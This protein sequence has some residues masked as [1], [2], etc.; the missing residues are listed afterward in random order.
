MP[1]SWLMAERRPHKSAAQFYL[2]HRGGRNEKVD[3]RGMAEVNINGQLVTKVELKPG[4]IE[5]SIKRTV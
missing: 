4:G 2:A 5:L 1:S 3:S